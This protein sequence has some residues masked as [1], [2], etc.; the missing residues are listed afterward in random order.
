VIVAL[1]LLLLPLLLLMSIK[2]LV[3]ILL[4][5]CR[6]LLSHLLSY[7]GQRKAGKVGRGGEGRDITALTN[8][9]IQ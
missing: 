2:L 7:K 8:R 4:L 1:I 6:S 5:T 3:W 9:G